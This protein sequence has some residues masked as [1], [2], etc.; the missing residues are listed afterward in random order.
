VGLTC[1]FIAL[2]WTIT[3]P[4]QYRSESRILPADQRASGGFAATAATLGVSVPGQESPDAGLVDI[5]NSR[6][7]REALLQTRFS[8]RVRT[9]Y[10]GGYE[11][12]E[13]SL[14]EYLKVKNID[15]AVG[16]LKKRLF[17]VRD[18]KTKLITITVDTESPEL[19]QKI[20]MRAVGLLDEFVVTKA[21]TRGGA[22]AAFSAKRLAEARLEMVGAEAAFQW[23]LESNRNFLVSA[24]P[25]VRMRGLRLDNEL[26]L[27]TQVVTTLAIAHEQALL[28]EKN[29]MPILNILDSGNLPYE[30]QGPPRVLIIFVCVLLGFTGF[31][32]FENWAWFNERFLV[33]NRNSA[34]PADRDS[35]EVKP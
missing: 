33:Q 18:I 31:W 2:L 12:R 23:F 1:G 9:W 19:S 4:N 11:Q 32:L 5:L 35:I 15:R 30:K 34:N 6:S 24:D 27:R 20:A 29:D 14:Y 16:A 3:L 21:Q 8:F 7:L 10:F 28:E 22:K 17:V 26:K 25:A 13:Q